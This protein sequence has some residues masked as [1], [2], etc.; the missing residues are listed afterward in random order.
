MHMNQIDNDGDLMVA[1]HSIQQQ[2][3]FIRSL[4]ETRFMNN[5]DETQEP[6]DYDMTARALETL[7]ERAEMALR[8]LNWRTGRVRK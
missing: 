2:G 6:I 3:N 4:T 7:M 1:G 5:K 8:Y